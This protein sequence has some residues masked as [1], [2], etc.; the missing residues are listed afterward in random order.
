MSVQPQSEE[1]IAIL[2]AGSQYGKVIDR[3]VREL[4]VESRVMPLNTPTEVLRGDPS[5]KGVI[6]SGGPSSIYDSNAPS[7]NKDL[8]ELGKPLLGICYGM[9]LLTEAFGG[10]VGRADVRE[11]GQDEITVDTTSPIFAGLS[12]RETV[13][14]THGDSIINPGTE[15][16]VMARS[17]ANIIAAVQHQT[18]P[19]FGVQFHPEV[20]LTKNGV[21]ILRNFLELCGC[22]F[23]FTM[24]DREEKALRLIRERT[25]KGQKVLC[26]ASGGVDSTVCAVLLLK[27]IGPER[28]VCVHIDHGFM[29]LNE[30]ELVVA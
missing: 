7:Y 27:A 1:Y 13:L 8:F 12:Q 3:R 22:A 21:Q 9:Q 10:E 20:E 4:R 24:E 6:I 29:R 16:K 19:L 15:L 14:L 11:D 17:S 5:I 25:A 26:L 23:A 30:S 18:R 2:D 28:V